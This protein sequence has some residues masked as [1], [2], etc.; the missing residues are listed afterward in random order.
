MNKNYKYALQKGSKHTFC[1]NCGKKEFKVYVKTGTN[2][3]V[4]SELFPKKIN[5]K[6]NSY[7]IL[8]FGL[9]S[10]YL[11]DIK[12]MTST[13]VAKELHCSFEEGKR[14]DAFTGIEWAIAFYIVAEEICGI[15]N[16]TSPSKRISR[17]L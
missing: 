16:I 6:K 8:M 4:D 3:V 9:F 17:Y 5:M 14:V 11:Q 15:Y 12:A 1:P 13:L 2:I 10:V 7:N